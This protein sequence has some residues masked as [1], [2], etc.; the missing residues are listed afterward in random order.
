MSPEARAKAQAQYDKIKNNSF[1]QQKLPGFRPIPKFGW[2][3]SGFSVGGLVFLIVGIWMYQLANSAQKI[4]VRYDDECPQGLCDLTV[5]V[6]ERMEGPVYAF[7]QLD[8]F[9]QNHRRYI[10]SYSLD[11]LRGEEISNEKDCNPAITNADMGVTLAA[12]GV[13]QLDPD[14]VAYPCGLIAKAYLK[15]MEVSFQLSTGETFAP[16]NVVEI[17]DTNIAWKSD[18]ELKFKNPDRSDWNTVQ[19]LDTTDGKFPKSDYIFRRTLHRV[20]QSCWAS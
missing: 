15:S 8:D 20:E 17:N 3:I 12:D 5:T 14:A 9:F 10:K 2:T 19:W 16:E 6:S 13:T 11:Q 1:S 18:R 7:Y 4:T